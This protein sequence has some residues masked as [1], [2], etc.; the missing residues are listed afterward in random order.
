MATSVEPE[1][2]KPPRLLPLC[3]DCNYSL[4]GLAQS[5]CPECG[6]EFHI[7]DPI[8]F[9]NERPLRWIDR[10]LMKPIG[11]PT[12][13]SVGLLS[14]AYVSLGVFPGVYYFGVIYFLLLAPLMIVCLMLAIRDI[15][16]NCLVPSSV[17]L[18]NSRARERRAL[19][20]LGIPLLLILFHIPL[21][22]V[23]FLAKPELDRV[24]QGIIDG[25]IK[26]PIKL[27]R[28]G[29]I[30]ISDTDY[31][32]DDQ[33]F[34]Y[35]HGLGGGGFAYCRTPGKGLHYNSGVDGWLWGNWYW[36]EDD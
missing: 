29:P 21:R 5:R 19:A 14:C 32:D 1:L 27:H 25:S 31:S 34:F 26:Q 20:I 17:P 33:F 18:M 28:A 36:W 2:A 24:A 12:F 16:R 9:N 7:Q 4:R 3:L 6:R 30:V 10:Q 8:S 22:I 13:T 11:W 35:I 15:L 23:F